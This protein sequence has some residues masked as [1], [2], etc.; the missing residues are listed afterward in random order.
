MTVR[1]VIENSFGTAGLYLGAAVMGLLMLIAAAGYRRLHP[2]I[3]EAE[4]EPSDLDGT[5]ADLDD[6]ETRADGYAGAAELEAMEVARNYNDYL[7]SAVLSRADPSRPVLDFGAGLG[8]HARALRGRDLDVRCVEVDVGLSR[9]LKAEG[10][11]TATSV[12]EFGPEAFGCI[13]SLNV[14]EHIED[15]AAALRE[16]YSATQRG[17]RLVVYVPA[18]PLV[19]STLDQRVGHVR[20]YRKRSLTALVTHA[21]FRVERCR[22]VDSLGFAA[23]LA[24]RFVSRSGGLSPQTV[25]RYDR[26]VFPLSRRIDCVTNRWIGKNLLLEAGR[27]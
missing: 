23:A 14:L 16:L 26:F 8:T 10:F 12:T 20:R 17:G 19:F 4:R 21:G 2:A 1:P 24:Y 9:A 13:Y 18:F 3:A 25:K 6:T 15:D 7:A 11:E 22:Y 5:E 27:D